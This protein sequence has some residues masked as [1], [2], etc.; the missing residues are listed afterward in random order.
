[1]APTIGGSSERTPLLPGGGQGSGSSV[2]YFGVE[3]S[4]LTDMLDPKDVNKLQALGG[5]E[6]ICKAL[7]VDPKVGLRQREQVGPSGAQQGEAEA[8]AFQSR[9]AVFGR[10]TLPEAQAVTFWQLLVA[11]YNDRT[12]GE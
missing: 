10:N 7:L 5:A 4:Q 9:R 2:S 3:A 8:E 1:M 11:A 6:Q 12:L